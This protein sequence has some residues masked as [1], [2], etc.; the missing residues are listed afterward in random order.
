VPEGMC[1]N[2][3]GREEY[4]GHFY[5]AIKNHKID[6]N[7]VEEKKGWIQAYAVKHFDGI[8]LDEKG[9]QYECVK[10]NNIYKKVD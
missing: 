4:G 8:K 7:N 3:W 5:E 1:P 2:C 6:L 9:G 10:C